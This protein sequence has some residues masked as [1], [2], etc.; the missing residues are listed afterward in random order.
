MA[1]AS[2]FRC[3]AVLA[4][5][6]GLPDTPLPASFTFALVQGLVTSIMEL[7]GL[8]SNAEHASSRRA[9]HLA[10]THAESIV[11]STFESLTPCVPARPVVDTD[12]CDGYAPY[13]VW[14]LNTFKF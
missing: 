2:V 13:Q 9:V 7:D 14:H 3:H 1:S 12:P 8:W 10:I 11:R 5:L 4:V 6:S